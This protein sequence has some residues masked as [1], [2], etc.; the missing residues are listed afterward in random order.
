MFFNCIKPKIKISHRKFLL[1]FAY[2]ILLLIVLNIPAI[3]QEEKKTVVVSLD[4][5]SKLIRQL[6]DSILLP[7]DE[8]KDLLQRLSNLKNAQESRNH[9]SIEKVSYTFRPDESSI[10]GDS[11]IIVNFLKPGWYAL[12]NNEA[13]SVF[14]KI[15]SL[16]INGEPGRFMNDNSM[17]H[18]YAP[19]PGRAKL[20]IR[21]YLN[22]GEDSDNI[23]RA[24][25]YILSGLTTESIIELPYHPMNYSVTGGNVLSI[26]DRKDKTLIYIQ[27]TEPNFSFSW[28]RK[29][30]GSETALEVKP[31]MI[32]SVSSLYNISKGTRNTTDI[33]GI[34]VQKGSEKEFKILLNKKYDMNELIGEGIESYSSKVEEN[35]SILTIIMSEPV[36]DSTIFIIKSEKTENGNDVEILPPVVLSASRQNGFVGVSSSDPLSFKEVKSPSGYAAID[37][38][39]LPDEIRKLGDNEPMLGFQYRLKKNEETKALPLIFDFY[40]SFETLT[41]FIRQAEA[42]TL[43]NSDGL[44]MS[45]IRY[46]LNTTGGGSFRLK[47]N[48]GTTLLSAYVDEAPANAAVEGSEIIIPMRSSISDRDKVVEVVIL[49]RGTPLQEDG[50]L[51]LD[52]PS[53]TIPTREFKWN[54]YLPEDFDY[55][56]YSGN[57]ILGAMTYIPEP[58][59]IPAVAGK[60]Y[61]RAEE[62]KK[63]APA[64]MIVVTKDKNLYLTDGAATADAQTRTW[65]EEIT[66]SRE[67]LDIS[68]FTS[69]LRIVI[70]AEGVLKQFFSILLTLDKPELNIS[71]EKK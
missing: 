21:F 43:L 33:I 42:M 49:T 60:G 65:N 55:S 59:P 29:A 61:E 32:A 34:Q 30:K 66:P 68:S 16:T 19:K 5:Y 62:D 63:N 6:G 58:K 35:R 69:S 45:R 4:E 37:A 47:L 50:M 41:A 7:I 2:T 36:I 48:P 67:Q 11:E 1:I 8:Y 71:Y 15:E 64:E 53:A 10:D 17:L 23:I 39:E 54:V 40:P 28:N 38:R 26:E 31:R 12:H 27:N 52:L 57:F 46:S 18:V 13:P 3:C 22:C 14:T 25:A 44:N 56:D 20:H 51:N 24:G 70:P 9:I